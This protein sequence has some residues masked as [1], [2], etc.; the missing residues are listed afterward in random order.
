MFTGL[1]E[2]MGKVIRLTSSG[3]AARLR[4]DAG[5]LA[6]GIAVGDSVAIDGPCLTAVRLAG[7]E[8]EFDLSSETR[9]RT[10][11]GSLRP[12]D[13]V[14]LE[15]SLRLG[16][17]LGGHLVLGHVDGIGQIRALQRAGDQATLTVR[18][19]PDIV[20]RLVLKGS[21]AVDGISLTVAGLESDCFSAAVIP[22]TLEST[23][24]RHKAAGD[25]VNIELDI[26]GRYVERLIPGSGSGGALTERFL[27][28]HGFK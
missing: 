21:V 6:E 7:Q 23:T 16:D 12:G 11:L 22:H 18:A 14:N 5:S 3:G 8:V 10:T 9:R 25:R 28:E 27:E 26:I 20:S 17:R 15:R 1:I 19:A 4:L 24:L 2:G 13:G